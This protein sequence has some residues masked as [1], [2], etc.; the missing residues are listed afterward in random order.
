M[1]RRRETA[2][3][4]PCVPRGGLWHLLRLRRPPEFV[5][6]EHP[7]A[8]HVVGHAGMD[9]APDARRYDGLLGRRFERDAVAGRGCIPEMVGQLSLQRT[10]N[11]SFRQLPEQAML[12]Q[13]L[14]GVRLIFEEFISQGIVC[15]CVP[16]HRFLLRLIA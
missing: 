8:P 10:L 5:K 9:D 3:G 2:A 16:G 4:A 15:R 7:L 1:R 12:P 14:L 6:K 11:K 13:D